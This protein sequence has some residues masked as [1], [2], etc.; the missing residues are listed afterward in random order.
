M[1][2]LGATYCINNINS[3]VMSCPMELT[4]PDGYDLQFGTN[5]IGKK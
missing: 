5:V 2:F 1:S 3:G 4:T